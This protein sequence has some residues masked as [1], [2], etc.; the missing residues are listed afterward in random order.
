MHSSPSQLMESVGRGS[1]FLSDFEDMS[2]V[3]IAI[4]ILTATLLFPNLQV[5]QRICSA[6]QIS[7]EECPPSMLQDWIRCQEH[8]ISMSQMFIPPQDGTQQRCLWLL[9]QMFRMKIHF[10]SI[11]KYSMKACQWWNSTTSNCI[12]SEYVFTSL[13]NLRETS[14]QSI[15]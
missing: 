14:P 3:W 1:T 7:R 8:F 4:W 10:S 6:M 12:F 2:D 15:L 11:F 9:V 13:S 5:T